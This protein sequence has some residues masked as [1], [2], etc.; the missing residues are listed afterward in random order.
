MVVGV[1]AVFSVSF[2]DA[3]FLGQLGTE[4]LAAISFTFPVVLTLTSLGIGLSA[5]ATSVVSRALG[6][7][8]EVTVSRLA[9]DS[10][11][12]SGIVMILAAAL[13]AAVTR[14]LFSLLGAEGA[15][16]DMVQDYMLIWFLSLPF[17]VVPM[18]G[19]GLMR[20]NGE[21]IAPS[22]ILL[23]G[24][25]L[26]VA[27]A[28]LLI[29]GSGPV[30]ALGVEGAAWATLLSRLVM[31]V[32]AFF[33]LIKRDGLLTAARPTWSEFRHSARQVLKVGLPAAGSNMINPLSIS[34]VTA[35]LASY[36]NEV[37]AGFGVATRIEALITVPML[38]LSSAIGPVAGQNWG[39]DLDG[40][41]RRAMWQSFVFCVLCGLGLAAVLTLF[42]DETVAL[43]TDD[44]VVANTAR[45]YLIFV[46]FT[47]GGYGVVITAS[48]ALNA[49]DK[50]LLGLG[51]T[52]LRS[53]VLY[54]PLAYGATKLGPA[55]V[56]FGAIAIA[57][58]VSGLIVFFAA[59]WSARLKNR[60]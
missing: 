10:L 1:A 37:V 42:L 32:A 58:V 28:P 27:F 45:S 34:I 26:N 23:A 20:A 54:V 55:W 14:P 17:L 8:G 25:L 43:F 21:A 36:G 9:T 16:L 31:V 49:I 15:V 3:Y 59:L 50:A 46:G 18:V 38:A 60:D 11:I 4:E 39:R 24:S 30:P 47:L 13:G 22:L 57:N 56:V 33:V 6:R 29:F 53:F 2:A 5:G 44:S 48:A 35:F 12:L 40:R 52:V 41:T 19:M 7:R 51:Y